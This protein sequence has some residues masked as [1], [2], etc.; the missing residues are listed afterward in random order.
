M[1][2]LILLLLLLLVFTGCGKE[3]S[4]AEPP[5]QAEPLAVAVE[6]D[7]LAIPVEAESLPPLETGLVELRDDVFGDIIELKGK[8]RPINEVFLIKGT[9]LLLKGGYLLQKNQPDYDSRFRALNVFRLPDLKLVASFGRRGQGPG[10]FLYPSLV[11]TD[12][13]DIL[14]YMFE[15]TLKM[16]YSLD[17]NLRLREV[18][19]EQ[20]HWQGTGMME[21]QMHVFNPQDIVYLTTYYEKSRGIHRLRLDGENMVDCQ[22]IDLAFSARQGNY[23]YMTGTLAASGRKQR[24]VYAYKYYKRILFMDL[25]GEERRT[26]Y[27][28]VPE[29]AAGVSAAERFDKNNEVVHYWK[30]A[31]GDDFVYFSYSGRTPIHVFNEN[32]IDKG[33]IYIEQFDWNGNPVRKFRLDHWGHFCI[34]EKNDKLYLISSTEDEPFV[35]YDLPPLVDKTGND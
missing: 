28:R 27:F 34:D 1:I 17:R 12:D 15:N 25:A 16:L 21:T 13:P 5:T 2:R 9:E 7:E 31:E 22:L 30:K 26:V 14:C 8:S 35:E 6:Q 3:E 29:P 32:K 4:P 24:V 33:Y 11:S 23:S 10:E 20:H 18:P 19:I